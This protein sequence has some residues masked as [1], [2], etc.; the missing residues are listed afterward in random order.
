MISQLKNKFVNFKKYGGFW[1]DDFNDE[2]EYYKS[3]RYDHLF[4]LSNSLPKDYLIELAV[5]LI[6]LTHYKRKFSLD[7]ENVGGKMSIVLM[8]ATGIEFLD[9]DNK[10]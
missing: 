7:V 10:G 6:T 4:K 1:R 5:F 9:S 8:D 2:I 3:E